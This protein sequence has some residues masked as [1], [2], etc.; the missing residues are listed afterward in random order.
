MQFQKWLHRSWFYPLVV[1]AVMLIAYGLQLFRL[2]F[3][4]DDWQALYLSRFGSA[5]VYWDFF[6]ADRPLSAWTYILTMPVLG[7]HP[8]AWQV[9]TLFMRWLSVMGMVWAF[10]LAWPQQRWQVR[11][12]GLLLAVY[13]GFTQQAISVA[14]SQHFITY[15]LFTLSLAGMM[16]AA[17]NPKRFWLFTGLAWFASLLHMLTMEYFVGLELLRPLLLSFIFFGREVDRRAALK[18]TVLHWL[19]YQLSLLVFGVYR[20]LWLPGM[21]TVADENALVLLQQLKDQPGAA[22]LQLIQLALR[23]SLHTS[24]FAW[25][26]TIAPVTITLKA[27]F[28][29]FSWAVGAASA[30]LAA[31]LSIRVGKNEEELPRKAAGSFH[32][33]AVILGIAA[34]LLGGLPVWLTN[35]QVLE[36]AWSDR[37]TLAP[38]LGAA[39]L[40]VAVVD[41]LA[42]S[43]TRK[44]VVLAAFL[45]MA[46]AA[47]VRN[48]DAYADAWQSQRQYYWQVSWRVPSLQEGTAILGPEIPFSYVSGI[49]L[50][51]A[52]NILYNLQPDSMQVPTW[53]IEALRYRNSNVLLDFTP[54]TAI[55]YKELRNLTF[56][57]N[58]NQALAVNYNAARGCVRV[59]DPIYQ[60]AP[61]LS[62]YPINEGELELYAI[63]HPEQILAQ[64]VDNGKLMRSIF[65]APPT[66]DWC[67]FYQKADL[68]RQLKDW[69]SIPGLYRQSQEGGY[70]PYNGTELIPFIEGFAMT[71]DYQQAVRL[72][73]EAASM[74]EGV[75]EVLCQTWSRIAGQ[76]G[77]SAEAGEAAAEA[78]TSLECKP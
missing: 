45:G 5:R 59:M 76:T 33:Q 17:L 46:V 53:F 63:S 21:L 67:Y 56:D 16:A 62:S 35:R 42:R 61:Y 30:A 72:S 69:E 58:T 52:Y 7:L 38:M 9:F 37:F 47:H 43:N 20:F 34:L 41:W 36:G 15:A 4:W 44:A 19:P 6:L 12:I 50:G 29:I 24:L 32:L 78:T 57:G 25:V 54:D 28:T 3:Y 1:L 40:L 73:G 75:D 74:S 18:K 66:D 39:V 55:R 64:P 13:P 48:S 51:F 70:L 22:L 27:K 23:D 71:A 11:W 2:G 10:S 68:A 26:N 77:A 31:W 65:G 49:S 60:S 8:W 14:Y